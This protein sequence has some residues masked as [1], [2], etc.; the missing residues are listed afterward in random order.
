MKRVMQG[1]IHSAAISSHY[2][3]HVEFDAIILTLCK[4]TTLYNLVDYNEIQVSVNFGQNV[5]ARMAIKSIFNFLHEYGDCMRE[6]WKH[7]ID[8]IIQLYKLKLLPKSFLE[9]EDFC[10]ASGKIYLQ[11]EAPLVPKTETSL[12]SSFYLYLSSESQKVPNSEEQEIIKTSKKCIKECQIEQLIYES[13]ILHPDSLNELIQY[14]L[15]LIKAP[16]SHKSVGI[17][18]EENLAVFYMEFLVKILIQNRDRV[19]PFWGK[20]C[21][22]IHLL[23]QQAASCGYDFLLRRSSVA[24]FKLAIYLMRNEE[25]AS[26][27]LQSLKIFL[28]LKP[29]ILLQICLLVATGMYELLKTSAQNIHSESDWAIVFSLLECVGAGSIPLEMQENQAGTKSDG[30]LSSDDELEVP[31]RGYISDSEIQAR[32]NQSSPQISPQGESWIIVDKD[33]EFHDVKTIPNNNSII[34]SCKLTEHSPVALVKCWESLAFIVRNVAHI[35]PYNFEICVKCIRTFVEAS[36]NGSGRTQKLKQGKP[37][38]RQ[39]PGKPVL[40]SSSKNSLEDDKGDGKG[41][42]KAD[43]ELMGFPERYQTIAIQLLDLMH[44]LHT[45]TAQ[46]FRWWAEEGS[47]PQCNAL[48]SQGWCPLLQG[49]ARISTDYRRQVSSTFQNLIFL[50]FSEFQKK[51]RSF[52]NFLAYPRKFQFLKNLQVRTSAITCLQRALLMH[53]LQ[54]LTGPEWASCFRQVLF[55]L[56]NYLLNET[57]ALQGTEQTLIEE[58]RMRI[59]TIMSK[60]FL[61]HLNPL[62]TLQNFNEL[63]LDIIFY[64][65]KFMK[66]GS[67]MLTEAVLES[68]KNMLLVMYSVKAFHSADGQNYSTLWDLTWKRIGEFLPG[69]KDELFKENGEFIS[70]TFKKIQDS[71]YLLH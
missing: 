9:I 12:F 25:L 51:S 10:E 18:Y 35:T 66:V 28:R 54:T 13:K 71:Q 31:E 67:D 56:M 59:A 37:N 65:E 32:N 17:P 70:R 14:L 30:A 43:G 39:K 11:Y 1:F 63:W 40:K 55:P 60:V 38:S 48:W 22:Q 36:I 42:G 69:L 7:V 64:L 57:S 20:C 24:L 3:L 6:S 21:E 44:T 4:F 2:D 29:K 46:I 5:K 68:L 50:N 41:E 8:I 62:M 49:I 47:V 26:T 19:L 52:E 15:T 58:S 27:I 34:Y 16:Q 45:R 53:D 23:V 33:T 61:H